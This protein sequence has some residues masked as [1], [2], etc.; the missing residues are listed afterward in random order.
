MKLVAAFALAA[1]LAGCVT[2]DGPKGEVKRSPQLS[3][4]QL[5][6]QYITRRNDGK[7]LLE[8][9]QYGKALDAFLEA[10]EIRQGN[11]VV[12]LGIGQAYVGLE[13]YE[14]AKKYFDRYLEVEKDCD[15]AIYRSI[16]RVYADHL[17]T[18]DAAAKLY[19]KA[20]DAEPPE[21]AGWDYL[22][23]GET[24][25]WAGSKDQALADFNKAL[26]QGQK[27]K[28]AKLVQAAKDAILLAA[29]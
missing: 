27:T 29:K 22:R 7:R 10:N 5:Q 24:E 13:Y 12:L 2:L 28:D 14:K 18:Y 21:A 15:P 23:R 17:E 20:I 8:A 11:P 9:K 26:E 4:G 19:G 3:E 16:A 1:A 6:E 25:L